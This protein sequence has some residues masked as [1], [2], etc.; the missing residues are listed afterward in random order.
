[1]TATNGWVGVTNYTYET[2]G[3][4]DRWYALLSCK[5]KTKMKKRRNKI[6]NKQN[7]GNNNSTG[8]WQ[9]GFQY[10][11]V[12]SSLY[13]LA[14]WIAKQFKDIHTL[15]HTHCIN[16]QPIQI[17][18]SNPLVQINAYTMR[19]FLSLNN[20]CIVICVRF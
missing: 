11:C 16:R 1:M 3:R 6:T 2:F 9:H 17:N 20:Y 10:C 5:T 19:F 12:V 18:K 7:T 15:S 13:I 4:F 14:V 8:K